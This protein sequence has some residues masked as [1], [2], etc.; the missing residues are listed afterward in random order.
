MDG[1]MDLYNLWKLNN[2]HGTLEEIAGGQE[3]RVGILF[4]DDAGLV[5]QPGVT[6]ETFASGRLLSCAR[7]AE[8][9]GLLETAV[10]VVDVQDRQIEERRRVT[11][12][13]DRRRRF[14]TR[15]DRRRPNGHDKQPETHHHHRR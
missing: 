10:N 9:V 13:M 1:W 5:D 3:N 15:R 2:S 8:F 6:A 14:T 12:L 11:R 7:P 4:A